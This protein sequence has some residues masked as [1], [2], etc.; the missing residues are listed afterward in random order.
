VETGVWDAQTETFTATTDHLSG[1]W[2]GLI[3]V[4]KYI[5]EAF[6]RFQG[7]TFS[8]PDRAFAPLSI[9][10]R[11]YTIAHAGGEAIWPQL[12]NDRG[13]LAV[14]LHSNS[15]MAWAVATAPSVTG[16]ISGGWK[17][18]NVGIAAIYQGL[19]DILGQDRAA[20]MPGG[21]VRLP[22]DASAGSI[23]IEARQSPILFNVTMVLQ[24]VISVLQALPTGRVADAV[25]DSFSAFDCI[26][27]VIN[28]F[29]GDETAEISR[30]IVLSILSCVAAMIEEQKGGSKLVLKTA[31][32]VMAMLSVAVNTIIGAAQGVWREVTGT[33]L[34]AYTI[35]TDAP[36]SRADDPVTTAIGPG[37][38]AP[39]AVKWR[40]DQS[41]WILQPP[42]IDNG[43]LFLSTLGPF[44]AI[45]IASGE[46]QWEYHSLFETPKTPVMF[47]DLAIVQAEWRGGSK[48]QAFDRFTGIERWHIGPG[49]ERL[50]DIAIANGR[51]WVTA[52]DTL[53]SIDP[54]TG[55]DFQE[56]QSK[57]WGAPVAS[58][59]MVFAHG[60]MTDP[61]RGAL[62]V[63]FDASTGERQWSQTDFPGLAP[64]AAGSSTV[65]AGGITSYYAIEAS[66]GSTRWKIPSPD[67]VSTKPT[68][69]NGLVFITLD[70]SL[71]ALDLQ[72]GEQVWSFS[73]GPNE[74]ILTQT[75]A[76]DVLYVG[77]AMY[78]FALDSRTGNE[79]WRYQ[80]NNDPSWPITDYGG[81]A[82]AAGGGIVCAVYSKTSLVTFGNVQPMRLV[83]E[84]TLRGAPSETSVERGKAA[85]GDSLVYLGTQIVRGSTTWIEVSNGGIRGWIPL[86]AIEGSSLPPSGDL[87]YVYVPG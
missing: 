24:A 28:T 68:M 4:G 27:E 15:N 84:T 31:L 1:F 54:R 50:S 21:L 62:L 65:F 26:T 85:I 39:I 67:R 64:L 36:G 32:A 63:G 58:E 87:E 3:D 6:Q 19:F 52:N 20:L 12:V 71:T 53:Y 80:A 41:G 7:L 23:R 35:T 22:F 56:I 18:L 72:S 66:D 51:G 40:Y 13:R 86:N 42:T 5:L 46:M 37:H 77:S 57:M 83:T 14:E 34:V 49:L 74:V 59:G 76:S 30:S 38:D 16:N 69:S 25:L 48:L 60:Y 47:D 2:A 29:Y 61:V 82:I 43:V 70:G 73:P 11:S 17:D 8:K 55:G 75:I 79:H 45:D 33:A 9:N 10:S 81:P 78:L 44:T